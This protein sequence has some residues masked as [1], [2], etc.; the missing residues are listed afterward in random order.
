MTSLLGMGHSVFRGFVLNQRDGLCKTHIQIQGLKLLSSGKTSEGH[1]GH[2]KNKTASF[3]L[4]I[5]FCLFF[6]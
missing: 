4:R 1:Q 3:S 6:N 2:M 5:P